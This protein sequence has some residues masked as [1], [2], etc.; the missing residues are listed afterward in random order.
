MMFYPISPGGT[1]LAHIAADTEEKAW[2][3]LLR[4]TEGLYKDREALE[5]RGYIVEPAGR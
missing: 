5:E 1:V 2:A 3:N 4:E